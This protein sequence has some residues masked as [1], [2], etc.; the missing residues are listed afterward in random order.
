[1]CNDSQGPVGMV[2]QQT[3]V[4]VDV[5]V[6]ITVCAMQPRM[7]MPAARLPIFPFAAT[8]IYPHILVWMVAT[9]AKRG[10]WDE[11]FTSAEESAQGLMGHERCSEQA[12][13]SRDRDSNSIACWFG[14]QNIDSIVSCL[15]DFSHWRK[16]KHACCP[17]KQALDVPVPGYSAPHTIICMCA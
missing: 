16:A 11:R 1:M 14:A 13:G 2:A 17:M 8:A 4:V 15:P 3:Q 9:F 7:R 12:H 6:S 10:S 5:E